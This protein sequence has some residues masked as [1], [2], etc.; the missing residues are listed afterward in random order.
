MA[1]VNLIIVGF[2]LAGFSPWIRIPV[3]ACGVFCLLESLCGWC[4][5]RACGFRTK[6]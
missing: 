1:G 6:I 2:V 5:L 3:F 4:V